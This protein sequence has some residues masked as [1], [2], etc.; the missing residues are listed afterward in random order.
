MRVCERCNQDAD[1]PSERCGHPEIRVTTT[2]GWTVTF[3]DIDFP[4]G[5]VQLTFERVYDAPAL[6]A[7][8]LPDHIAT[9][10]QEWLATRTQ[11]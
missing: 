1:I 9:A 10:M 5:R 4:S 11:P 8:Y 7:N 3:Y 6:S 2:P